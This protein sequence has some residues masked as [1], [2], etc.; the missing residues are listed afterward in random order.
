MSPAPLLTLT[1]VVVPVPELDAELCRRL[2]LLAPDLA[3]DP[4]E[5]VAHVTLLAPFVAHDEIGPDLVPALLALFA[6]VAGFA[7]SLAGV[8]T[9][10]GGVSYLPPEP[11]GP[12]RH[13]TQQLVTRWPE[14]Q[15]YGGAFADVVPH[16]TVPL[17]PGEDPDDLAEHLAATL[18]VT[19]HATEA[20][21]V[22]AE[23]DPV[24]GLSSLTTLARL[25]FAALAA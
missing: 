21:L 1:G 15:P 7:F 2:H 3:L 20:R 24:T 10:P 5:P 13:L 19:V 4:D 11:A 18:P 25:P 12:F 14:H 17:L 22:S 6:D 9:F 23:H 16:L 8:S